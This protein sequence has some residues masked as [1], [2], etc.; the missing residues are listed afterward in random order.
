MGGQRRILQLDFQARVFCNIANGKRQH[1]IPFGHIER[2][3]SED[4]VEFAV[5]FASADGE[6]RHKPHYYEA[7]TLEEKN[8]IF[9]LISLIVNHNRTN[10]ADALKVDTATL[11]TFM[12][13]EG[14]IGNLNKAAAE[15]GLQS[16]SSAQLLKE[17]RV[18]KKGA[19]SVAY[20]NWP[21]R[22]LQVR[23]GELSYYKEEE[24]QS[25]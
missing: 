21:S 1:Q 12:A 17:G 19:K 8:Q 16:V 11:G 9:R 7:D 4:G 20:F 2:I 15:L 18:E 6:Q 24:S 10:V 3:E 13:E 14:G 22:W 23:D 25:G 5:S